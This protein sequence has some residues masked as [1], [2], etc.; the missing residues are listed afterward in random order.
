M[1]FDLGDVLFH[2]CE[3]PGKQ[4]RKKQSEGDASLRRDHRGDATSLIPSDLSSNVDAL[5]IGGEFLD[6]LHSKRDS[7]EFHHGVPGVDRAERRCS[8]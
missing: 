3:A 8:N 5:D 1:R 6:C 4:Q 2:K 7:A